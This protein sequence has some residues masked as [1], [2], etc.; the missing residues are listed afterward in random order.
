MW[1][2]KR[3]KKQKKKENC[4]NVAQFVHKKSKIS[5]KKSLKEGKCILISNLLKKF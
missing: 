4:E 2:S 5:K 3:K 1:F